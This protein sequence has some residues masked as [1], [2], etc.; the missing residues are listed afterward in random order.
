MNWY[1]ALP[2]IVLALCGMAILVFG[3]LRKGDDTFQLCSWL[4]VG[5]FLL[6]AILVIAGGE[7]AAYEGQFTS[8]AF[9]GFVKVLVLAAAALGVIVS[10]DYAAH[11]NM[12][13]FEF[14]VLIL[15]ATVGMMLMVS[16]SNLMTLYV[17]LELQSLAI[18]VLASFARDEVRSSEAG[19]KYF[20]LGSL[21]S[22]LLLYGI[23]LVYG[24]TGT[25]DFAQL[26]S[27]L[28]D[29]AKA[30]PGL[31]VGIVFLLA[32]L[33]FKVSAV[34]FHMWTPDVYE[35]AP[36]PVTA[37]LGTA[38]KVAAIA[39]LVRAM[40][41]PFG[42]LLGQWQQVVVLISILSM[43]LGSLAAIGQRNIKRL[44]AYSSIGHMGYALIGLA[45]GSQ[46]GIRGVLIYMLT[47]V[48][49][50]LG[51]FAIILAMRRRGRML[52]QISDLSGLARTDP[53]MALAMAVFMFS[54][55]GIPPFSGFWGKYFI[56]TSAVQSGLWTLAV[57]GVLT[58][59]IGAY[60]YIRIVKVMYFDAPVEAFDARPRALSVV[61]ALSAVFTTFFFL[62]PAPFVAA[63][64]A[65]AKALAG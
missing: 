33:A 64:E 5:A 47:Y 43:L 17:G 65:A 40:A 42:D 57:I 26:A 63:A 56:F 13:R 10:L 60:Y 11:A 59:V 22:G 52:E 53:G 8:D 37:F 28:S 45:A 14:P 39:M 19:L 9:S 7:G 62:F 16:A 61:A 3:V 54:M 12:R 36:T 1:L 48:F 30:S 18:Y 2:E 38:P 4:T 23:S 32:G 6:A 29:P 34:P 31:I 27:A 49:M 58:S 20:V 35:G 41:T 50:N 15:Y 44:M 46:A 25:M 21:A 55:A 51:T 24:F